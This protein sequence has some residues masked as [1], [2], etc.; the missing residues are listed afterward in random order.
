MI[1]KTNT[2]N[3]TKLIQVT[4][5]IG[6]PLT[7]VCDRLLLNTPKR[8]KKTSTSIECRHSKPDDYKNTY[9]G[10]IKLSKDDKSANFKVYL[11]EHYFFSASIVFKKSSPGGIGTIPFSGHIDNDFITVIA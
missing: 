5:F 2:I 3:A 8:V 4:D 9:L 10:T 1:R 11:E 7:T 6:Y